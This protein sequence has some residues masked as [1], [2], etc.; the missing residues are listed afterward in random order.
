MAKTRSEVLQEDCWN[1]EAMYPSIEAWKK[2]FEDVARGNQ[3]PHWPE[4]ASYRGKLGEGEAT[5][6]AALDLFFKISRRLSF[7]YT[8]AH[9][10]HDED[11]TNEEYK[12]IFSY[13][14]A[15]LHDFSQ[16]TAWLEPELLAL[17]DSTIKNYLE[18]PVLTEYRFH[19]EKIIRIKP[20][21]LPPEQEEIM[22][23]SGKA[24]QIAHKAFSALN[25]ADFKFGVVLDSQGNERE[26][27]HGLY[28]VYLRDQDRTLRKNAFL[29][30]HSVYDK[31]RNTLCELLNGQVQAHCFNA[32]V[33][34][35][36][37]CL[38]AA[39]FPKNIDT[40]VYHS[41]IQAVHEGIGELH[42]YVKL[43]QRLPGVDKLHLY[44][45]YVPLTPNI[46]IKMSYSEAE[47]LVIESIA[48]LGAQY[49]NALKKG[50]KEQRWVDR[51][52]NEN[53]RSGAYS[54]GCYDSAPYILMNYRD[55]L[56]HVFTLA[57]EAG[58]SMHSLLTHQ[59]QPYHYGDY[60]IF[61]A[62]VAST[63][64]EDL[65]IRLLL[66]R[67]NTKEEKIF[68]L[69]QKIE[70]IRATL[71]R[72]TMF[73]EF[74]LLI[75]QLAENSIPL[76]PQSLKAEFR[77]LNQFYF[78]ESVVLDEESDVE[79]SRIPHFYYNFYVFQYS[80]GISAATA[81][82]EG[83]TNGGIVEREKYLNFLR[84]GSSRYPIEMLKEAGV[85]MRS[86]EP[87]KATIAKFGSLVRELESLLD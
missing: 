3:R 57:H 87:V 51:Y 76:T 1:V 33:R 55:T 27:T 21:V 42:G 84:G 4:V 56:R 6:K 81:L 35:Y 41:L 68:L 44:D 28:G 40:A 50:F 59:H 32:Q 8:F 60:P 11:L 64:N 48:P 14:T 69:T 70:D 74:E 16:E 15:A 23:L 86:S 73:A 79:W 25:D 12:T 53:K 9:L 66:E 47:E 46:E 34:K 20:H 37:S 36:A 22:A 82:A 19:I 31:Y 17:S 85:D 80:T 62:E 58:H 54:S 45:M 26:L 72:Q 83:V 43:R 39:L 77:K 38:D 65:L 67:A 49:Q 5:L 30:M 2:D 29:N 52:E 10:R 63:F 7:L 24:L 75:H 71:F 61:L 13:A 18:S 78:G